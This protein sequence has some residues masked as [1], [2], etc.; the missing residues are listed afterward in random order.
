MGWELTLLKTRLITRLRYIANVPFVFR[1]WWRWPLPKLGIDTVLELRDGL[2]YF[3]RAG[4][5]DLNAINESTIIDPYLGPGHIELPE[6]GIVIDVGAN[7]GDFTMRAAKL[8]SRGRV[9]AIEPLSDCIPSITRNAALNSLENIEIFHTAVGDHE[10]E[11]TLFLAGGRT[12]ESLHFNDSDV[13]ETVPLTTLSRF[14]AERGIDRIDLLKLDCEGAEWNILPSSK[15]L[16]PRIRQICMEF[17]P[18]R[19]WTGAK[20]A[21]FLRDCGYVVWYDADAPWTGSLWARRFT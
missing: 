18:D 4:T 15:D 3:V 8:C 10:G 9:Y 11:T 13:T 16:L 17:H 21:E 1:N 7:I 20:L 19:G 2:R 14:V 12:S 6:D 5:T